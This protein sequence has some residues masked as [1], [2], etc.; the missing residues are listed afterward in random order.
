MLDDGIRKG[1]TLTSN[2]QTTFRPVCDG[3]AAQFFER[4]EGGI[5]SLIERHFVRSLTITDVF[6]DRVKNITERG[7]GHPLF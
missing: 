1:T 7:T 2:G 4:L 6:S 3:S 5:D